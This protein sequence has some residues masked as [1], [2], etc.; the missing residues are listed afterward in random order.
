M[1]TY[2]QNDARAGPGR[3]AELREQLTVPRPGPVERQGK[4]RDGFILLRR[5]DRPS[6]GFAGRAPVESD[7]RSA[8]DDQMRWGRRSRA[9]EGKQKKGRKTRHPGGVVSRGQLVKRLAAVGVR[10]GDGAGDAIVRRVERVGDGCAERQG[11]EG[12]G[13]P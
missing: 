12:Q 7:P 1:V 3:A 5:G 13:S 2:R 10:R 6:H 9:G 11:T 4:V 8:R